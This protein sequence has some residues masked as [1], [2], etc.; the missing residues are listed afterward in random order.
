[1][2]LRDQFLLDLHLVVQVDLLEQEDL[3]QVD[4]DLKVQVHPIEQEA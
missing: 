1:M 2:V 4:H 3:E